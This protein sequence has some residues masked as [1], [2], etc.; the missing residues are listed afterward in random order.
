MVQKNRHANP[1]HLWFLFYLSMLC[2]SHI[3]ENT[4]IFQLRY[5]TGIVQYC[6]SGSCLEMTACR[7]TSM[8]LGLSIAC[9]CNRYQW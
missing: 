5:P 8:I 2:E 9:L 1:I 6:N 3:N 7:L 4:F